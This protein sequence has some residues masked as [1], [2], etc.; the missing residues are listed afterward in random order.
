MLIT[1]DK[2]IERVN[3][4]INL[5]GSLGDGHGGFSDA[6]LDEL[7]FGTLSL[8]R[9]IYGNNEEPAGQIFK[10]KELYFK[11]RT[12]R[13]FIAI[14]DHLKGLLTTL[15]YEIEN[16]LTG[17]LEAQAQGEIFG[18]FISLAKRLLDEGYKDSAAVLACG[19]LEDSMKKFAINSGLDVYDNDLSSVINLLKSKGFIKGAQSGIVQS[20]VQLRNKAFHAQFDKI[21]IPEI[22]SLIAFVENFVVTNFK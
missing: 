18:D 5:S 14:A 22:S 4:L 2:A 17:S 20:Y 8:Y 6:K 16:D 11:T 10:E 9:I 13:F 1:K 15:K 21:G 3:G 7:L 19:A 12:G